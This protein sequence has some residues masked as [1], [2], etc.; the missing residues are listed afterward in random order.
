[1][2]L[3]S[4]RLR[5]VGPPLAVAAICA[6]ALFWF[7]RIWIPAQQ[8]YLN[9][10]NLRALR[11]ISTQIK[12]KVD[13]FDQAIDHA[14]DSFPT[15]GNASFQKDL[16]RYVKLFSSELEIVTFDTRSPEATVT[17]GD[18][19]NVT[20]QRD[21]GR[22][23]L[24][25]GYRHEK[26]HRT[27]QQT[28]VEL[29]ARGDIDKATAPLLARTDFDALL[30]VDAKGATIAQQSSSGLE[31]TSMI[32]VRDRG[33]SPAPPNEQS[34]FDR[35]RGTTGI[36]VVTIGAADYMLYTQPVQ[37]SL[38]HESKKAGSASESK[39]A[40]AASEGK[41]AA[42]ASD[43]KSAASASEDK[44]AAPAPE[45]WTLTG[46]VRLDR[47]RA[48]SSTIPTTYWL[49]F[50][51]VLALVCF[52]IPVL[53]PR[54]LSPR[55]RLTRLDS[56][57]IGAAIFMMMALATFIALDLR[58]FGSLVPAAV[59]QQLQSVATS[60]AAHVGQETEAVGKQ[61]KELAGD[62]PWPQ[63]L[64]YGHEPEAQ[65]L[66]E[67]RRHLKREEGAEINLDAG[68]HSGSQA[69]RSQ[70]KPSWSCR[71]GV[72]MRLH[73]LEY[74]FFKRMVWSDDA[75]WQRIKWST[76]AVVTPFVNVGDSTPSYVESLKLARRLA[77]IKSDVPRNGV[78][79]T[80]SPNTG[81]KVTMF[82]QAVP[83]L[84][85]D[86]NPVKK[87]AEPDMTGVTLVTA[88]V[89]LTEPMLPKNVQFAVVDRQGRVLFHTDASRSLAENM[90]LESEDSPK[91]RALVTSRE[92]GAFTARYLGRAQRFFVRPLD[93]KPFDTRWSL[94]VFQAS[95]VAET[96]NLGTLNLAV[97]MFVV[98]A[99]ALAAVW[100]VLGLFW[101]DAVKSLL[102]PLPFKGPQYR[103]AAKVGTVAGLICIGAIASGM[104]TNVLIAATALTVGALVAMFVI[105]R[106]SADSTRVSPAWSSDF[107]W[108]RAS[109]LSLLAA[110]PA[111]LCFH[112][113]YAFHSELV[114]KRAESQLTSDLNTRARRISQQ[115]QLVA[116]C[117]ESDPGLQAC[118]GIGDLVKKR[119]RE[120]FWDVDVP[121]V[122]K[123]EAESAGQ[124]G[125]LP[126]P[127]RSFLSL[128]YRPYNDI[129]ADL[130]M[131]A[132]ARPNQGLESWP[133]T[134]DADRKDTV[135]ME[136]FA[137]K[138]SATEWRFAPAIAPTLPVNTVAWLLAAALMG[139][140]YLLV[141]YLLRPIFALELAPAATLLGASGASEDT[142]LLVL[143][144]A[145]SRRTE[146]LLRHP[147]VRIFDVRSLSF[148]EDPMNGTAANE[149]ISSAADCGHDDHSTPAWADEIH[150]ATSHPFTIVALDHLE[151]RLDDPAFRAAMLECLELAVYRHG[152]TIWCSSV[153]DPIDLLEELEPPAPDR[154]RWARVLEQFRR[155]HLGLEVDPQRS[156]AL[157]NDLDRCGAR[158]APDVRQ[159]ILTE[160]EI[161]P[162]LLTIAEN[163]VQ[164]LPPGTALSA[165]DVLEEIG[166]SARYFYEGLWNGC[167]TSERVVLRQLAE[168]G[169]IN[170][171]NQA[172]VSRMLNAGLVRH[173]QTFRIMNETFRRFVLCAAPH[174]VVSSWERE[175]VSV[176]WG[177]IA[178]TGVTV[179]FGL[180][181]LLLLTQEQLVDAWISYVP[182][183]A[184]AIPTVWKVLAGVQKGK[185]EITA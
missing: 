126:G 47:F 67:I 100:T 185:I 29:I 30:L 88:P 48:A 68:D 15:H 8:Q 102:W 41:K 63:S 18:P 131:A 140:A 139:V 35:L 151:H 128:A 178:T 114:A 135:R 59:D 38:L 153:R 161:S 108:A 90:F 133:P 170:P 32:K 146:R 167:A 99:L 111:A 150:H 69:D 142:S 106:A 5:A 127:L 118:R 9:E 92:T 121:L 101:P 33:Q 115:T 37:L 86:K 174:D 97:S 76:S 147:R 113:S 4:L 10:R 103:R 65:S 149:P 141:R 87:P 144:P 137:E 14:I 50:G 107:L 129:A 155:E 24:Y 23:Y 62:R 171:N 1:M 83:L 104:P 78:L 44:N 163:L 180:A 145:G 40:P 166:S 94:L 119:T 2:N 20:I 91:L 105:V 136:R 70:C 124:T 19:P 82:W 120:T 89:S 28:A 98:Y 55:E 17:P 7:D 13:N 156:I 25:L 123:A 74:P 56:V 117:T 73:D 57:S 179:A 169:L 122:P 165:E 96:A 60:M 125:S 176:P 143:G 22:N 66:D 148:A 184:P 85:P 130:L 61:M 81:E 134:V 159:R 162:E 164:R 75:G 51:A 46:L 95:A 112:L 49:W 52:A 16:Q 173:G 12:A 168:E 72:L 181:G 109:M 138:N 110:V 157:A 77:L 53:K 42:S 58:A 54:V 21:E 132:P 80:A 93:L 11:T 6:A 160:C 158:L 71:S 26:A 3:R 36:A 84:D 27:G 34:V 172:A 177:T 31:L 45:E 183:L 116:V 182:A 175:G 43:D 79:V 64:D 154:R 152:A 39:K